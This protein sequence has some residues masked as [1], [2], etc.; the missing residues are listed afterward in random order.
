M[1]TLD[2]LTAAMCEDSVPEILEAQHDLV[3]DL[4]ARRIPPTASRWCGRCGHEVD[5]DLFCLSCGAI[6]GRQL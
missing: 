4:L 5:D 1:T 6:N 2:R 3:L